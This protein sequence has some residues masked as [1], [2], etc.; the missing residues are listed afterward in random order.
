MLLAFCGQ[1]QAIDQTD[2]LQNQIT[3]LQTSKDRSESA[4]SNLEKETE[5]IGEQIQ[6]T[7]KQKSNLDQQM[8]DLAS[9]IKEKEQLLATRKA[10]LSRVIV[11]DYKAMRNNEPL[12]SS[13]HKAVRQHLEKQIK[14][15]TADISRM[16]D[17][18]D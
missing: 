13:S 6:S 14:N 17:Q 4:T 16:S 11:A 1:V 18:I 2:A 12:S 7:H 3:E 9:A 10:A 8:N 15:L 5:S